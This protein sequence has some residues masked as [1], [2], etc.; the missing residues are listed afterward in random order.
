M[1]R[2]LTLALSLIVLLFSFWQLEAQQTTPQAIKFVGAPQYTDAELMAASGF[3]PGVAL[4]ADDMAARTKQLLDTGLIDTLGYQFEGTTLILTLKPSE[5]LYPIRFKNLPFPPSAEIDAQLHATVPLYRGKLPADGTINE[6][7]R[8][9]LQKIVTSRGMTAMIAVAPY[10]DPVTQQVAFV[11]FSISAP[12]VLVGDIQLEGVSAEFSSTIQPLVQRLKSTPYDQVTSVATLKETIENYYTDKGYAAVKVQIAPSAAPEISADR[13]V[14]PLKVTVAE[15]HVYKMG[16]LHVD[17]GIPLSRE[18]I[19]K[20]LNLNS[21]DKI[22]GANLRA[23]WQMIL[24]KCKSKGYLNCTIQPTLSTDDAAGTASYS[25]IAIPGELYKITT[26]KFDG[27]TEEQSAVL[28]KDW[29]LKPGDPLDET[30]LAGFFNKMANKYAE[31]QSMLKGKKINY[32]MN[33]DPD[34]HNISV[35]YSLADQ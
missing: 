31:L 16:T 4:T 17:P 33:P 8:A 23:L 3:K 2:K 19:Y 18:E 29:K 7:V 5:A 12:A 24:N 30:Y 28:M 35:V 21:G 27:F 22:K 32:S 15:G 14:V 34:A 10:T 26:V 9:A 6:A 13:I 11:D 20:T 25:V 1:L